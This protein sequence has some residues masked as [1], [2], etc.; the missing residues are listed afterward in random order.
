[1]HARRWYAT[2]AAQARMLPSLHAIGRIQPVRVA[3]MQEHNKN[4]K[5]A[6]GPTLLEKLPFYGSAVARGVARDGVRRGVALGSLGSC[7]LVGMGTVVKYLGE[8]I[9]EIECCLCHSPVGFF[10]VLAVVW[11]DQF[12]P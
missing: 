11:R 3:R 10:L 8:R 6:A 2:C 5:V 9:P 1:M 12:E 7:T 4:L